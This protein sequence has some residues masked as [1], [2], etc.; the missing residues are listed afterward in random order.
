MVSFSVITPVYNR[1]DCI[2]RC[3]ES[4]ANQDYPYLE[5]LIVDD[6]SVDNTA[7]VIESLIRKY[8]FIRFYQFEDNQ[9]VN[10]A[11]NHA[12]SNSTG[13]YAIFLDSDDYFADNALHFINRTITE[14]P[15]YQHYLFS[16]DDRMDYYNS[17]PSLYNRI[18]ELHFEDFLTGK[19]SGDF[20]HVISRPL[21]QSFPFN[22]QLRIYEYINFLKLY[23]EEKRQLFIKE[24]VVLR[25]RNRFD[26]VTKTS[27]LNNRK[28]LNNQYI[29]LKESL[30][31]FAA[32]YLKL[33]AYDSLGSHIRRQYLL[34]LA[35]GLYNEN[36]SLEAFA[37]ENKVTTPFFYRI[38]S[39]LKLGFFLKI[40]IFAFS[41][42][43][44]YFKKSE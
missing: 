10:A 2:G 18:T 23:R 15:G 33:S 41:A 30:N 12:I 5:M 24:I 43:K 22:E 14:N 1:E 7:S 36:R 28:S 35:L 32:D 37:K 25:E 40:A 34:G 38:L 20:A 44:N 21:L 17:H 11:R 26:S 42:I 19:V 4:V 31:L 29:A 39:R 6:A 16:Q 13:D 3:I 9:G 27:Q 8:P